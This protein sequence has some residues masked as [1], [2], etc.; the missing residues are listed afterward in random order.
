MNTALKFI[1][2][3]LTI[4][5]LTNSQTSMTTACVNCEIRAQVIPL[6]T[7]ILISQGKG[8]LTNGSVNF[9]QQQFQRCMGT[10]LIF[11]LL[12]LKTVGDKI[13]EALYPSLSE[14]SKKVLNHASHPIT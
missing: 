9:L 13:K 5:N 6:I 4:T 2:L 10:A 11:G 12:Q 1:I 3:A 14:A 7:L 8:F